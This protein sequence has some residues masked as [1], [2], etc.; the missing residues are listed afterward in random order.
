MKIEELFEFQQASL[1]HSMDKN[2]AVEILKTGVWKP[3][4]TQRYWDDGRRRTEDEPDYKSHGKWMKGFSLTRDPFYAM[5]WK[6]VMFQFDS[7]KLKKQYKFEPYSWGYHMAGAGNKNKINTRRE[8]EEFLIS[9]KTDKTDVDLDKNWQDL[10]DKEYEKRRKNKTPKKD[11]T[12]MD[13]IQ[14]PEG[15]PIPI[16]RFLKAFYVKDFIAYLYK[17]DNPNIQYLINHPKFRGLYASSGFRIKD[18]E[19][20]ELTKF[21]NLINSHYDHTPYERNMLNHFGTKS[22]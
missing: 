11:I 21:R 17:L 6:D 19:R 20:A 13:F 8:R 14:S 4:T 16:Y 2:H 22:N 10:L 9:K 12:Y 3:R 1:W 7:D 18:I 5:Q 15:R